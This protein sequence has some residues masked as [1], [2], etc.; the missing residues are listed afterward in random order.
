MALSPEARSAKLQTSY[1]NLSAAAT[2][3]NAASDTFGDA[4]RTL[5]E[6]LNVGSTG[7]PPLRK[8]LRSMRDISR[9]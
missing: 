3:L 5:D 4:I 2:V 9:R 1:Q 6:A 8:R 7:V